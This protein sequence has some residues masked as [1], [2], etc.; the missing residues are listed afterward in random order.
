MEA[1]GWDAFYD[2][3]M[4]LA[5]E[6][7]AEA[8][9][10]AILSASY[11]YSKHPEVYEKGKLEQGRHCLLKAPG[12]GL[13]GIGA[14]VSENFQ[15]RFRAL[16]ARAGI[17]LGCPKG[18]DAEDFWLHRLYLDLLNNNS[19]L[20]FA[21]FEKEGMILSVCAASATFCSRLERKGILCRTIQPQKSE[22]QL[23]D[24]ERR[25]WKVI[26][27][28]LKSEQYCR[29]LD[30]AGIAPPRTGVWKDCP[31]RKYVSVYREGK[32]WTHRIQDEKSKI[33]RKA[34]LAGLA[35]E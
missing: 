3:F 17:A 24:R 6:E 7:E 10:K 34:Q 12:I 20:L 35:S 16:A 21:P 15:E 25:I 33:Q 19:E 18:T 5:H 8:D 32:P 29:E 23:T 1:N 13:W 22:T 26:Q 14:G 30:N 11:S 31:S 9:P 2:R 27:R 28:G 4:Q